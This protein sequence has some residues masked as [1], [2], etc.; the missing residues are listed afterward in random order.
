[1]YISWKAMPKRIPIPLKSDWLDS[2]EAE[3]DTN[4]QNEGEKEIEGWDGNLQKQRNKR[5]G[6]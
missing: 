2:E 6:T 1:M 4:E 3:R 5:T